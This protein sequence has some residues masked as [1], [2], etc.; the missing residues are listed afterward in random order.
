M[1][2]TTEPDDGPGSDVG[3]IQ[4]PEILD[5]RAAVR[6]RL[7]IDAALSGT[8]TTLVLD[9]SNVRFVDS[10]GLRLLLEATRTG[11]DYGVTVITYDP[12]GALDHLRNV[13]DF[14][15]Q[16]TIDAGPPRA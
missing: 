11:V 8:P 6:F 1:P 12:A 15:G 3:H 13:V 5:D 4:L 7:R 2:P 14:D 9:C 10:G 16:L